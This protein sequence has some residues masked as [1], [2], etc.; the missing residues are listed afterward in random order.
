MHAGS[1]MPVQAYRFM[2]ACTQQQQQ[3]ACMHACWLIPS[4]PFAR[5]FS[6][7]IAR[8]VPFMSEICFL[9]YFIYQFCII[10]YTNYI[11][12]TISPVFVYFET[13]THDML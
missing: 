1:C 12:S 11:C 13:P 10:H 2:Q 5:V 8:N 3:H 9:G 6:R 7:R 4:A